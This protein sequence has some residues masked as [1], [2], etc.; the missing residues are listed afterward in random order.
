V[1]L[2]TFAAVLAV[3]GYASGFAT[4][5]PAT[6]KAHTVIMEG[7]R[8]QPERLTVARGDTVVWVNKDLVAHTA[9]SDA[10][11]FDSGTIQPEKSWR[12]IATKKGAFDY[13]CTFHP[14]MKGVLN[15]R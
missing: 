1:R 8:F 5:K 15:V 2:I 4:G 9:T 14:A 6:S 3:L 7:V 10:G 11:S 13:R 12:F